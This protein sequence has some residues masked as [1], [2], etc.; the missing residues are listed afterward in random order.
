MHWSS[1]VRKGK[2]VLNVAGQVVPTLKHRNSMAQPLTRI[3][4]T[5]M[6]VREN[7][8]VAGG[9]QGELICK[10]LNQ[11]GVVFST[12]LTPDDRAITNGV[13]IYR[14]SFGSLRV[15]S[16]NNDCCVRIFDTENFMLLSQLSFPWSVNHTSVSPDGKHLA[17]VG[18][19]TECLL[20]DE[21]SGKVVGSLKGHLDYSFASA[22]HPDSHILATGNQDRT[23][24]L[25]D[26]R[27]VSESLVVLKGRIGAIRS[28]KFSADGRFLAMAEI[29]DFI[30]IHDVNANYCNPQEIDIFGEIAGIS[31]SPDSE[32]L[33]V[34]IENRTYGSLMEFRRRHPC[35]YLSSMM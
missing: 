31:F 22:W 3:Q 27:K 11:P 13:D 7:L 18:D 1:I 32:A 2:E 26:V 5:S 23:C 25:W 17:V 8:V 35:Q 16:A 30:H 21:Q 24:R 20:A 4:I 28:I 12:M 34:G 9:F 14:T 10:H 29:A 15:S 19:T 6:A 33:F